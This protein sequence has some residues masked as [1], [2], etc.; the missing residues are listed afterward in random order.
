MKFPQC[1]PKLRFL[2]SFKCMLTQKRSTERVINFLS[3]DSFTK[4]VVQ[5]RLGSLRPLFWDNNPSGSMN[6]ECLI[7]T[8]VHSYNLTLFGNFWLFHRLLKVVTVWNSSPE[9]SA[10]RWPHDLV[11]KW[12]IKREKGT[13]QLLIR[14]QMVPTKFRNYQIFSLEWWWP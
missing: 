3:N 11:K 7:L 1:A 6:S 2:V 10:L 4:F 5:K 13:S 12:K 9:N 8:A 14:I